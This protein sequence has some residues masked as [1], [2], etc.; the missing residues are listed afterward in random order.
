MAGGFTGG[1]EVVPQATRFSTSS[2]GSSTSALGRYCSGILGLLDITRSFRFGVTRLSL[3]GELGG[4]VLSL[5]FG[6]L[7]RLKLDAGGKT[8]QEDDGDEGELDVDRHDPM[9]SWYSFSRRS[10]RPRT[11]RPFTLSHFSSSAQAAS[12]SPAFSFFT[13][14]ELQKA[15]SPTLYVKET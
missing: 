3:V 2:S 11:V 6:D 5:Q 14:V 13:K 15:P 7:T 10:V 8:G 1:G 9:H 4:G 12:Y